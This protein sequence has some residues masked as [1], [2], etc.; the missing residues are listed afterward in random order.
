MQ[1]NVELLKLC[2]ECWVFGDNITEGMAMEIVRAKKV[3]YFTTKC[4][5]VHHES[6]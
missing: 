6:D 2:S 1:M 4:E 5:E 3:R